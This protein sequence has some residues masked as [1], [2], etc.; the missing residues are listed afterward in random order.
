[1]MA[2]QAGNIRVV[3]HYIDRRFH[4]N[5]CSWAMFQFNTGSGQYQAQVGFR[6]SP[7]GA[8]ELSPALQRWEKW[9]N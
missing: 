6:D 2:N 1:M 8:T 5:H 3:F 9:K 7:G 4:V